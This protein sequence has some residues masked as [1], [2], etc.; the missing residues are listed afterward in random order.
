MKRY[1][2]LLTGLLFY[3]LLILAAGCASKSH[4]NNDPVSVT[5]AY[6]HAINEK[7]FAKAKECVSKDFAPTVDKIEKTSQE[8]PGMKTNVEFVDEHYELRTGR[9]TVALVTMGSKI[10]DSDIELM[11]ETWLVKRDGKW[12]VNDVIAK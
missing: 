8:N 6:L 9:D 7:D 10:K 11:F 12:L 5:K 1:H 3:T 2:G 4:V